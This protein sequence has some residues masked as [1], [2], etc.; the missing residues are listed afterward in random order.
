M[1]KN[2]RDTITST[3]T[4]LQLATPTD[5]YNYLLHAKNERTEK[6]IKQIILDLERTPTDDPKLTQVD[7]E[8]IESR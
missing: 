3:K 8:T 2:N 5:V 4:I 7:D 6:I 1:K